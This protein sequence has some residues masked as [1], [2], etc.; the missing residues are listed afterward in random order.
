M[1]IFLPFGEVPGPISRRAN[2]WV[3]IALRQESSESLLYVAAS[4][5]GSRRLFRASKQS[6]IV[7]VLILEGVRFLMKRLAAHYYVTSEEDSKKVWIEKEVLGDKK[8]KHHGFAQRCNSNS[9]K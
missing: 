5:G 9:K 7:D 3:G 1:I 8:I 2:E 4:A 6:L